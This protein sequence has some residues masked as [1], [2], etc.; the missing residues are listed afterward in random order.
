MSIDKH[1]INQSNIIKLMCENVREIDNDDF[2]KGFM[3]V[4]NVFTRR[5]KDI[6]Y[7]EFVDHLTKVKNQNTIT[8]V[9]ESDGKI[10]GTAKVVIEYKLH[11]NLAK[12]AHIEDVAVHPEYRHKQI[13]QQLIKKALEYTLDCYKVVLSCK[14]SLFPFYELQGFL[15]SGIA[16]TLYNNISS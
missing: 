4:I 1:D 10:V 6:T 11:N 13:G 15:H 12:M 8:L 2:Y 14:E 16:L 9:V 7:D 3:D 5:P